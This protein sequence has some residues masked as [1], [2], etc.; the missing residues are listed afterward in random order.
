MKTIPLTRDKVALVDDEDYDYLN[1]YKWYANKV[2]HTYYAMREGSMS[3][4]KRRRGILM[5]RIIL[6]TPDGVMTD[7]INRNGL[8]NRKANLRLCTSSENAKHRRVL[9]NSKTGIKGVGL[10]KNRKSRYVVLLYVNDKSLYIGCY[11][12]IEAAAKAYDTA[13][14]QYHGDFALTNKMMGLIQ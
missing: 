10:R 11:K 5:H 8:D 4:S 7:H 1:Q 6:D 13:A 14:L 9:S 3:D 12:T 2:G